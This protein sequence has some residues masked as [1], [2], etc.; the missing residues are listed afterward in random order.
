MAYR[1]PRIPNINNKLTRVT[2][3]KIKNLYYILF[4]ELK[5]IIEKNAYYY[6]K[7]YNQKL[8]LKEG[9]KVY[10]VRKNINIK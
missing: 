9:D 2:I 5:F 6:N 3:N 1:K 4:K 7:R 8:I 10:L